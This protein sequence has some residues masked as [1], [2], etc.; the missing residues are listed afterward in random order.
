MSAAM[1]E[2]MCWL[3]NCS[4]G[5]TQIEQIM[6]SAGC[7][8]CNRGASECK[9]RLTPAEQVQ[10][11][12]SNLNTWLCSEI[13]ERNLSTTAAALLKAKTQEQ[14]P[15]APRVY[16]AFFNEFEEMAAGDPWVPL[17]RQDSFSIHSRTAGSLEDMMAMPL[18]RPKSSASIVDNDDGELMRVNLM[19]VQVNPHLQESAETAKSKRRGVHFEEKKEAKPERTG[20]ILWHLIPEPTPPTDRKKFARR[21]SEDVVSMASIGSE[22]ST[23][24]SAGRISQPNQVNRV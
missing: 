8:R 1:P 10:Q 2:Y 18:P 14:M 4:K 19:N 7:V 3:C 21:R 12:I 11:G 9:C 20:D 5:E 6:V 15:K 23:V 22:D 13:G 17:P 16:E 24:S